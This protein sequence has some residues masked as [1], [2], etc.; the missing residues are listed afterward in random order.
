MEFALKPNKPTCIAL[1]MLLTHCG[2]KRD[3]GYTDTNDNKHP[4]KYMATGPDAIATKNHA[5]AADGKSIALVCLVMMYDIKFWLGGKRP[6]VFDWEQ[7]L[8]KGT[9]PRSVGVIAFEKN[10]RSWLNGNRTNWRL[11]KKDGQVILGFI[12]LAELND[13]INACF[14]SFLGSACQDGI[15][16]SRAKLNSQSDA[17][18]ATWQER[19]QP[20]NDAIKS[21]SE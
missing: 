17:E 14:Q 10:I 9:D 21:I 16:R 19:W 12:L 11:P 1:L 18:R 3:S 8:P 15:A 20:L 7:I 5:A 6:S 13:N 4:A 2:S